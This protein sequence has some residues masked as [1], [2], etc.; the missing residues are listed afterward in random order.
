MEWVLMENML[1]G[2]KV[3]NGSPYKKKTE[4]FNTIQAGRMFNVRKKML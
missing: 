4:I 1:L 3:S 2:Q